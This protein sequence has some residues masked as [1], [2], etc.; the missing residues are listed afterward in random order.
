MFG[1]FIYPDGTTYMLKRD[2]DMQELHYDTTYI[3]KGTYQMVIYH[4]S[5][6]TIPDNSYG[7]R[8]YSKNYN[9]VIISK[10]Q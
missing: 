9:N 1:Y 6:T 2:D 8:P 3:P 5:N 7:S 4:Y 10:T